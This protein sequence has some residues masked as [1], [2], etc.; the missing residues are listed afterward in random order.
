MNKSY[1]ARMHEVEQ[2]LNDDQLIEAREQLMGLTKQD[3]DKNK[4]VNAHLSAHTEHLYLAGITAGLS[5]PLNEEVA[6]GFN[7]N[8]NI[9]EFILSSSHGQVSN[10]L[11]ELVK[12]FINGVI[13]KTENIR[14]PIVYGSVKA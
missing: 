4:E 8:Q 3:I 2:N 6:S 14:T 1:E 7:V 11:S 10:E 9:C 12:G 5:L 13:Q